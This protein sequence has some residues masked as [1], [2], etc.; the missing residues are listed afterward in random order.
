MKPILILSSIVMMSCSKGIIDNNGMKYGTFLTIQNNTHGVNDFKVGEVGTYNVSFGALDFGRNI[1]SS[2]YFN[3]YRSNVSSDID[4][5]YRDSI[6]HISFNESGL[7]VLEFTNQDSLS[8]SVD[9]VWQMGT[10]KNGMVKMKM[11][12]DPIVVKTYVTTEPLFVFDYKKVKDG[13]WVYE[14]TMDTYDGEW[15]WSGNKLTNE[16]GN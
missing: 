8:Y 16:E 9:F 6:G 15:L 5:L 11:Y 10:K 2:W 14:Q 4:K 1:G 7:G 3:E 13:L 12:F